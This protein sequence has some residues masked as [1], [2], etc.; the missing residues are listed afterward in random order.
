MGLK[1][2]KLLKN[3]KINTTAIL[4]IALFALS[5][6]T[7][8]LPASAQTTKT[9][10][11]G[12]ISV[13]P[14]IVG[15]NGQLII[16]AW[17]SPAPPA[18]PGAL[19]SS[20]YG[21]GR[22]RE[23]Y[24]YTFT[25]PDKS[26]DV[27][28]SARPSFGEGTNW[29]LYYP[30]QIGNW[31]VTLYWQGDAN[32]TAVTSPPF[33]FEVRATSPY[34]LMPEIP[35]PTDYWT[36][37]INGENR[38]WYQISGSWLQ[39]SYDSTYNKYNPY[40]MGPASAHILWTWAGDWVGGLIGGPEQSMEISSASERANMAVGRVANGRAFIVRPDGTHCIDVK[41]GE[42]YWTKTMPLGTFAATPTF[43][44]L[45]NMP[46]YTGGEQPY[47][48]IYNFVSTTAAG[49]PMVQVWD[50]WQGAIYK[51][52]TGPG[53]GFNSYDDNKGYFYR[54][55][56]G[57]LIKWDPQKYL[58][59]G[60]LGTT[61]GTNFTDLIVWNVTNGIPAAPR[62]FVGDVGIVVSGGKLWRI[63]LNDGSYTSQTTTAP[64]NTVLD[65]KTGTL[66]GGGSTG[67]L[68]MNYTAWDLYGNQKWIS[69]ESQ[70]PFGYFWSYGGFCA[71]PGLFHYAGYDGHVYAWNATTGKIQ[72]A[73]YAGDSGVDTATNTWTFWNNIISAGPEGNVIVYA[74]N[75]EHTPQ[76]P[77][78]R[79]E[80]LYGIDQNTGK[81]LWHIAFSP[82]DKV[83]ADG[84]LMAA[85]YYDG[86]MYAFGKGQSTTTVT[87]SPQV[88]PAGSTVLISGTVMDISP[89]QPNTPA[90]SD[91]SQ[92]EWMEYIHMQKPKPTNATGVEVELTALGP[93]GKTVSIGGVISDSNG[94]FKTLWKPSVEGAYTITATFKGSNSYGSSSA[95]TALGVG[96]AAAILS[97]QPTVTP[98]AQP[99]ASP[100]I[101]PTTFAL[102][103]EASIAL[104]V[105]AAIAV[106]VAVVMVL[107]R[108]K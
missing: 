51:N 8:I 35:L 103:F 82:L 76:Q 36:R 100:S 85:N 44:Y 80:R 79:G 86:L 18:I 75:G 21:I 14:K 89:A 13:S 61:V 87:A 66:F 96:P 32:F 102:P 71:S 59:M 6:V 48:N 78:W 24:T 47:A 10:T 49:V 2:L 88:T 31:S 108:R 83:V 33:Y 45:H 69:E 77:L 17:T 67:G 93:D 106:I 7:T 1:F 12:F 64:T 73:F 37:P 16:N 98:S 81:E 9:I 26:Q 42:T 58:G 55:I 27:I 4:L 65:T 40:S 99:T 60:G 41:T 92:S 54:F 107:R 5:A 46:T 34:T 19:G 3:K 72:W 11:K 25:R 57:S 90:I 63:N 101:Q 62:H 43:D 20:G 28:V 94:L 53:A 52:I 68:T 39:A 15:V 74:G 84:V 30:N 50:I 91:E 70:Y 22:P 23:N 38:M 97:A 105:V 95:A 56:N 104:V 29:A